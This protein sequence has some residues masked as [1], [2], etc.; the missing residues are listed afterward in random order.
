MSQIAKPTGTYG[1]ILARGMACGHRDFY[2]NTA[3]FLDL[4]ND[5]TYLEIGFGSGIFIK[6]YA[7]D[8]F[9]N[10]WIRLF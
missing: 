4:K 2:K 6:K 8:D 1:K 5:D 9:E 7:S 10:C 3:K